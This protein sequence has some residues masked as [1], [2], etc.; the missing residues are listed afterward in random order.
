[1]IE[2]PAYMHLEFLL[3]RKCDFEDRIFSWYVNIVRGLNEFN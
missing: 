3:S 2:I 1:M